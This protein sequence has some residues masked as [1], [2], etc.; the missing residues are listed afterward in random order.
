[1]LVGP[2]AAATLRRRRHDGG[3]P[4]P[5]LL[6]HAARTNHLNCRSPRSAGSAIASCSCNA[7]AAARRR[8]LV[9]G[10]AATLLQE[11]DDRIKDPQ[12]QIAT[13]ES[14]VSHIRH[15]VGALANQRAI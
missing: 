4:W 2:R 8:G 6:A 1:M 10:Y 13:L 11:Q 7:S 12:Q 3:R 15:I 9:D 5:S 14:S